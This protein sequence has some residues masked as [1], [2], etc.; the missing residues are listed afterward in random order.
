V[1]AH[2]LDRIFDA[3]IPLR[4]AACGTVDDQICRDCVADFVAAPL[5]YRAAR[6]DMPE[7][8]ALGPFAGSLRSAILNVKF[9]YRPY[10]AVMLG[11]ILGAKLAKLRRPFGAIVP[12]PLHAQRLRFRGFNQAQ[13]IAQGIGF[14]LQSPLVAS[15][16]LRVRATDAQSSLP[17]TGRQANVKEAFSAGPD[18]SALLGHNILL[19]D[20]VVTTG[21]TLAGCARALR[22][23]G[24]CKLTA[25][26]LASRV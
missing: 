16:L 22:D 2:V 19:V 6:L 8:L 15:A 18:V 25:T 17:L 10:A 14:A 12:V 26:G 1:L 9:R 20:D 4:C 7:T 5:L 3:V 11:E 21:A 24:I 23:A 13:A